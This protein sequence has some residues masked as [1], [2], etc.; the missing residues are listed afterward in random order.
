MRS[1]QC[2][3]IEVLRCKCAPT[4]RIRFGVAQPKLSSQQCRMS[5]V[6]GAAHPATTLE[7][8]QRVDPAGVEQPVMQLMRGFDLR[9]SSVA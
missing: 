1:I 9:V 6:N 2:R 5:E 8:L 3:V 7:F 4:R